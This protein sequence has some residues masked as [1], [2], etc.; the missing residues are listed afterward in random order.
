MKLGDDGLKGIAEMAHPTNY[1]EIQR[2]LGVT[3]FFQCF[4]K[5]YARI[6]R[7]LNNLLEAEASK[8]KAQPVDLPPE[9]L[10]AF[11]TMKITNV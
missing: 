10:E 2:F 9:A 6:A 8:W 4:I 5:T 11:N 3:G 7:P 1:T